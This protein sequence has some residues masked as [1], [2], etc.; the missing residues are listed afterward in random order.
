[1][2]KLIKH[3]PLGLLLA[4][5]GKFIVAGT[6]FAETGA[7]CALVGLVALDKYLDGSRKINEVETDLTA[8]IATL[9]ESLKVQRAELDVVRTTVSSMRVAQGMKQ[10]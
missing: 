10:R 7:I 6:S 4:V 1:M 5:T 3:L 8:K 9:E 2:E